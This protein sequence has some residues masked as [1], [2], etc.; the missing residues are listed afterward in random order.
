[1]SVDVNVEKLDAVRRRLTVTVPAAR[2]ADEWEGA[3]R[4]LARSAKVPGFRPGRVP[5]GVLEKRFGERLRADIHDR[6]MRT[7]LA[8][9]LE[10]EHL[11]PLAPPEILTES[12]AVDGDFRYSA[13][14]EVKPEVT[15]HD[16]TG[17]DVE[18]PLKPTSVSDIDSFLER[19]RESH[20]QLDPVEER[21]VVGRGDV[22]TLDFTATVDGKRLDTV[23]GR[24]VEVGSSG[25][26]EGFDDGLEGAVVGESRL[27]RVTYPESF[28]ESRLAGKEVEFDVRV[29]GLFIKTVPA[30]DDEFAK[31]V[32]DCGSLDDLREKVRGRFDAENARNADEAVRESLIQQ[33]I[34]RHD[35]I[36]LPASMVQRRTEAL[37]DDV[38][39]EWRRRRIW[40]A[41]DADL[42]RK[43]REDF[44]PRARDQVRLALVLEAIGRQEGLEVSEAEVD[45]AIEKML[46]GADVPTE[47]ASAYL[48]HPEVRAGVH[49]RLQQ[50]KVLDFVV[51]R[52]NVTTV[53][54]ETDIADPGESD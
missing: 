13:T 19:L 51:S 3:V 39:E 21:N 5:R 14:V 42:V 48:R 27:I 10:K 28:S 18:R 45:D 7:S 50:S 49:S 43:L 22:A 17:L 26:P 12:D 20:A 25:F 31:D 46:G 23:E 40:P 15:A 34:A 29:Q 41:S 1:M 52:A 33:L 32:G 11:H 24:Q 53:E 47:Q 37:V 36:E 8:E 30:L 9:A 44:G 54:K 35:E 16:Y 4:D 6:L 2:V 38:R